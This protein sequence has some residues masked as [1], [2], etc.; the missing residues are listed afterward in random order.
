MRGQNSII[1]E[2]KQGCRQT[3]RPPP[4]H[5]SLMER[6]YTLLHAQFSFGRSDGPPWVGA[7]SSGLHVCHVFQEAEVSR[8]TETSVDGLVIFALTDKA[9]TYT[10]PHRCFLQVFA[11][12]LIT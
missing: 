1:D 7:H 10:L 12:T 11:S 5:L 9:T 8:V 4:A 6:R 2:M 3:S